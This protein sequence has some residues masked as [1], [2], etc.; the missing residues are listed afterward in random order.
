MN[1]ASELC[2]SKLEERFNRGRSAW[3]SADS[4]KS[5]NDTDVPVSVVESASLD[6]HRWTRFSRRRDK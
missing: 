1:A 4:V 5:G 6:Y 2:V 3:I